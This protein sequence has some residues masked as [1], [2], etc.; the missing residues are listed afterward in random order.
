MPEIHPKITSP[1]PESGAR[2]ILEGKGPT[3][4]PGIRKVP[5][6]SMPGTLAAARTT[7]SL[8]PQADQAMHAA[9]ESEGGAHFVPG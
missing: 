8:V 7:A 5:S 6:T 9:K 2:W 3:P 1:R 4:F